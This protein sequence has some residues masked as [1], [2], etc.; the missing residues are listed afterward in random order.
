MKKIT[1][2]LTI[3]LCAWFILGA[4]KSNAQCAANYSYAINANGNVTFTAYCTPSNTFNTQYYWNFGNSTTFTATGNPTASVTYTANGVYT[5]NLLF[6]TVPSCSNSVSYTINI[7]NAITPTCSI[8]A[9][10][11]YIQ[12]S[13]GF[14]NFFS[15]STGTVAGTSYSWHFGDLSSNGSGVSTSHTY[16]SNGTYNVVLYAN[17]NFSVSC[18]DSIVIP[19]NVNSFCT[20]NAG[21]TYN[22]GS[23]GN[24][25]F[26]SISTGTT[27]ATN[28]IW[29]FGDATPNGSGNPVSHTY[30]NNGV[31]SATLT[32]VNNSATCM[33]SVVHTFT[34]TNALNCT[35]NASFNSVINSNGLVNFTSTSTGTTGTTVFTWYYGDATTGN[36]VT[37]SHTYAT[38]SWY[39]V[40]LVLSDGPCTHTA[41]GAITVTTVPCSLN[42]SYTYTQGANGLVNFLSNST[43]TTSMS[44]YT[45]QFGDAT[46]GFNNPVSHNYLPGTYVATLT[47]NNGTF[48]ANCIDTYTQSITIAPPPCNLTANYSYTIGANGSV[49]FESYSSGTNPNT[50][51]F[52]DFGDGFT[53]TG[54]ITSHTYNSAGSYNVLLLVNNQTNP[55]CIDTIVQSVNVTGIP[56]IANSNF[57]LA[58]STTTLVWNATP[59]FPYNVVAAT[60]SWGDNTTSNTLYSSHTYSASGTYSICLSVS[61]SCGGSSQ[62]CV[63]QF[64]FKSM[65]S[66]QMIQVNVLPPTSIT[67]GIKNSTSETIN[68]SVFPNPNSGKFEVKMDGNSNEIV[69]MKVYSL[70]GEMIYETEIANDNIAKRIDL[71]NISN[72]IYFI[73]LNS[74]N[75]EF[76]KKIIVN[77]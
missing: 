71:D 46:T 35:L 13:N 37:S 23:N 42:A 39:N 73:K 19:V 51:Y 33:S 50:T 75:K 21:F 48:S 10:F 24:V 28:Y 36:G 17:N 77:K 11:G 2:Y 76:T 72:G 68:W 27:V 30:N 64:I 59:S 60:W 49:N 66:A 16:T 47:V 20:L 38:N 70:I 26:A 5:V 32:A 25:N 43:G 15:T 67:T 52:W 4:Q 9:N 8:N 61:V 18:N 3:L 14:V 22:Q 55:T 34:I 6:L 56:C 7:T 69:K 29:Q 45:W 74:N 12:G 41:S 40:T 53:G 65:Q 1:T 63:N 57:S 44:Y 54:I 62:T 31:Y 58:P